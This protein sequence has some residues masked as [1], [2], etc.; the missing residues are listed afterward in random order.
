MYIPGFY[1]RLTVLPLHVCTWA[2]CKDK[3]SKYYVYLVKEAF[4]C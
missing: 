1:L 4:T 2:N 3:E